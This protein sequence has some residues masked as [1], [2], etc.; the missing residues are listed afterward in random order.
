MERRG[1]D[2]AR[3]YALAICACVNMMQQAAMCASCVCVHVRVEAHMH[4]HGTRER[5]TTRESTHD[6]EVPSD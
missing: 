2:S 6:D 5:Q 1:G 4:A 3:T